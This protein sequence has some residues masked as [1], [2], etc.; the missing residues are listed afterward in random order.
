M[1]NDERVLSIDTS[2]AQQIE[3]VAKTI[4]KF[5]GQIE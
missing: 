4:E 3:V 5:A 2:A 1:V